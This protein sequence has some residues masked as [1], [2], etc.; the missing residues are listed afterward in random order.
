MVGKIE[1]GG[2]P[3]YEIVVPL[4]DPLKKLRGVS[5]QYFDGAAPI[6]ASKIGQPQLQTIAGSN[7]INLNVS[8]RI[9][10]APL[11]LTP[12]SEPRPRDVTVQASYF[13]QQ[14][15][16]VHLDPIIV[17]VAPPVVVST[18]TTTG[19][20]GGTTISQTQT[21]GGRTIRRE[22]TI[23]GGAPSKPDN[24]N[25]TPKSNNSTTATTKKGSTDKKDDKDA[26]SPGAAV[27]TNKIAT[28][29]KIPNEEVSGK[30]DGVDFTL[31][32]AELTNGTLTLTKTPRF[33]GV[34]AEAEVRVVLFLKSG[35]DVSG[36]KIIVNGFRG[37]DPHVQL[38]AMREKDK[39]PTTISGFD[40]LLVLEFGQYD[41]DN[42]VQPGKIYVC[43]PDRGKSF[44]A[45]TFE[46]DVR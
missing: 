28:M 12:N 43:T 5:I 14:G 11:Q 35:E 27:W 19:Q 33:R 29:K 42:K 26:G 32:R 10:R 17:K 15:Q 30:I 24:S 37:G 44:V 31:D 20:N 16:Q 25:D 9:A 13:N 40:F 4:I 7:A 39:L 18:T 23:N 1:N 38:S 22:I 45:G 34:F 8:D 46:A 6:D 41:I 36:R 2:T 21:S 3:T